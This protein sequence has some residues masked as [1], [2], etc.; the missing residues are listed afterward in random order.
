MKITLYCFV[1]YFL[2]LLTLCVYQLLHA[3]YVNVTVFPY[4]TRTKTSI[5]YAKERRGVQ[6]IES[7]RERHRERSSEREKI[8]RKRRFL[9][10]FLVKS[11][12]R[13]NKA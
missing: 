12:E 3:V 7:E 5:R 1:F 13:Q 6:W 9:I 11:P 10:Q 4:K 8:E 2:P